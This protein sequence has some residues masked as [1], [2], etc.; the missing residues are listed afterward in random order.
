MR[1]GVRRA[2]VCK[3]G[4]DFNRLHFLVIDDSEHMRRILRTLL[5]TQPAGRSAQR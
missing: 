4:I 1:L 5:N 2:G 3:A